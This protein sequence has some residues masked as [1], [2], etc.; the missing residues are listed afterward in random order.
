VE[1]IAVCVKVAMILLF[2]CCLYVVYNM[3][4]MFCLCFGF[5]TAMIEFSH[6]TTGMHV[7]YIELTN[8]EC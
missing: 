3:L 7:S 8:G 5:S 4:F 2:I 6:Q 1:L